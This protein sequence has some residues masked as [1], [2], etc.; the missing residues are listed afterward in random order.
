VPFDEAARQMAAA[1]RHFLMPPEALDWDT[2]IARQK[3]ICYDGAKQVV[4]G[5]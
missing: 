2:V 5:A 3:A 1:Y 4:R